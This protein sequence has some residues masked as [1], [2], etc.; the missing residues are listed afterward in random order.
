MAYFGKHANKN[1]IFS[2]K[3]LKKGNTPNKTADF[4]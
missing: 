2:D 1:D 3:L 4:L